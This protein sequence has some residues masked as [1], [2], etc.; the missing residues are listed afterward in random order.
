MSKLTFPNNFLDDE[1]TLFLTLYYYK[2]YFNL[3]DE[4]IEMLIDNFD[5]DFNKV[6]ASRYL[7]FWEVLEDSSIPRPEETVYV[8]QEQSSYKTQKQLLYKYYDQQI[9]TLNLKRDTNHIVYDRF[10][11]SS[12]N[13]KQTFDLEQVLFFISVPK[14]YE[15]VISFLKT[16]P[17]DYE[18]EDAKYVINKYFK[19]RDI[20]HLA[21]INPVF[22]RIYTERMKWNFLNFLTCGY[23]VSYIERSFPCF[24]YTS[25]NRILVKLNNISVFDFAHN[26]H[27]VW[28]EQ[29][30]KD[31]KPYKTCPTDVNQLAFGNTYEQIIRVYLQNIFDDKTVD[32][33]AQTV[34]DTYD[35]NGN[36]ILFLLIK[37]L[38]DIRIEKISLEFIPQ[39]VCELQKYDKQVIDFSHTNNEGLKIYD[40]YKLYRNNRK[41]CIHKVFG[42]YH[43]DKW[44]KD[45]ISL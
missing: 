30:A 44:L 25:N 33:M 42:D 43:L 26:N 11:D 14:I 35:E 15:I 13:H 18:F 20:Y 16:N 31:P 4:Q 38:N 36:N 39:I 28:K 27:I 12:S 10:H 29:V 32:K 21:Y 45:N 19:M 37:H 5:S 6:L 1:T 34:V 17:F 22:Q 24:P 40:Y 23:Y 41:I 7:E 2:Q 3:V 8:N 9:A